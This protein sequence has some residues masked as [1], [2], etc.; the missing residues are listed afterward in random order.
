[1][2]TPMIQCGITTEMKSSTAPFLVT[3]R[4]LDPTYSFFDRYYVGIDED[5][6]AV[7]N[8]DVE[9]MKDTCCRDR[10]PGSFAKSFE[11]RTASL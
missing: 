8:V 10:D 4:N 2:L 5:G 9:K 7:K 1:M 6:N 11:S 3:T